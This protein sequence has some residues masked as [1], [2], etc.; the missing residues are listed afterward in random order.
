M[1][2]TAWADSEQWIDPPRP[3]EPPETEEI[4]S[5]PEARVSP[6]EETPMVIRFVIHPKRDS[7]QQ[8]VEMSFSDKRTARKFMIG[9]GYENLDHTRHWLQPETGQRAEEI[10]E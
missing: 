9:M 1:G 3:K 7:G 2:W 5:R 6:R 10:I 8:D 4:L